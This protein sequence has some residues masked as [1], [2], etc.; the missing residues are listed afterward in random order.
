LELPGDPYRN[1]AETFGASKTRVSA[2]SYGVVCVIV[3]FAVM[4][5]LRIMTVD[6]Q[7]DGQTDTQ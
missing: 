4:V 5:K 1:S 7:S 3:G 6:R 2:L